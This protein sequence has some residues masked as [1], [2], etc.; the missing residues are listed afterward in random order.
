MP[1]KRPLFHVSAFSASVPTG[2]AA[3]TQVTAV[4]DGQLTRTQSNNLLAGSSYKIDLGWASGTD[5]AS[6]RMVVPSLRDMGKPHLSPINNASGTPTVQNIYD[7][8]PR[9]LTVPAGEEFGLEAFQSNVG[10]QT[11]TALVFLRFADQPAPIGQVYRLRG[12][13]T[14]TNVSGSWAAGQITLDDTL[15]GGIFEIVGLDV[16]G[17]N[18][19]GARLVFPEGGYRP[20]CI[21]RDSIGDVR[22]NNFSMGAFGSYGQFQNFAL[23]QLEIFSI[24]AGA[25]QTIFLDIIK[26][27][28]Q[29]LNQPGMNY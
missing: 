27:S 4:Q 21:A 9:P 18:V 24:G 20:G 7:P 6:L 25:S 14:I 13:S 15:T 5:L 19:V 11:V 28:N 2:V 1:L 10:A 29:S 26:V 8:G 17:A 3:Y 22:V 23:P 12:T 16:I